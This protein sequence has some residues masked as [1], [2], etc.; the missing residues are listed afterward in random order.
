MPTLKS[1]KHELFA[2]AISRGE[3]GRAAYREAGYVCSDAAADAAASRLL[4]SDKVS[5]R[6]AE[7]KGRQATAEATILTKAK[8]L[9]M[10]VADRTLARENNQS[11]AAIKADELLGREVGLFT[12]KKDIRVRN[13]SDLSEDELKG[14]LSGIDDGSEIEAESGTIN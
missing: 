5:N 8:V 14:L 12:E 4:K 11:A 7:L 10:L 1:P 9:E 13:V 6:V 3:N 2:Q